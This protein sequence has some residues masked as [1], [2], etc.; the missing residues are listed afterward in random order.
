MCSLPVP[1]PGT[2][3]RSLC[4]HHFSVSTCDLL[5]P[6]EHYCHPTVEE[7]PPAGGEAAL[8]LLVYVTANRGMSKLCPIYQNS[9]LFTFL[10]TYS[11]FLRAF[12]MSLPTNYTTHYYIYFRCLGTDGVIQTRSYQNYYNSFYSCLH[13]TGFYLLLGVKF[14]HYS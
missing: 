3:G 2:K 12:Q 5:P 11:L 7:R 6:L 14:D 8:L 10:L 9:S 1:T 13:F 4:L